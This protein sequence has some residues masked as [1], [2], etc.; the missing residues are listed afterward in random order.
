MSEV[1]KPSVP[2]PILLS[3]IICERVIIDQLTQMPSVIC[4]L[5]TITAPRYPARHAQLAFFCE[6]TNGHGKT[7]INARLVD[8]QQD[9]KVILE[10]TVE[11]RFADVKQVVC[12]TFGFEGIVFPHP[13]EY[14]FQVLAGTELLGERR[15]IC[16]EINLQRGG[17]DK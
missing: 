2:P 13:G 4:V 17:Q 9:D 7:K 12:L 6:F 5:Q 14:R 10:Q 11:G 15:I 3:A 8:V 1:E 16:R